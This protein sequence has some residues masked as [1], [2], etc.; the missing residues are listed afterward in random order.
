MKTKLFLSSLMSLLFASSIVAQDKTTVNAMSSEISDNLDLRA[1]ASIFGDSKD[2][3]DFENRL[4]DP[5]MQLSNLDLNNDNQVDYLRVIETVEGNSHL[6]VVQSVLGKDVFQDVATIEVERDSN[7]AIQVQV[8][9]DVYMYGT[10][11]IYE[12]VYVSTPVIYNYFWT[13]RYT[14]YYSS[15]YWGYYPSYYTFW[16]PYPVYRYRRNVGVWI[17]INNHYNYGYARRNQAVYNNY[18]GRRSNGY[19]RQYPNRS[20][21]S[22][23]EGFSN[24]RELEK[25]RPTRDVSNGTR[26]NIGTRNTTGT[27][28][29]T[30][31]I[32]PR[33][34][35]GSTPRSQTTTSSSPRNTSVSTPRSQTATSS[36]PR[37]TN[38]STPRSQTTNPAITPRSNQIATPR[39]ANLGRPRET[40]TPRNSNASPSGSQPRNSGTSNGQSRGNSGISG[41]R[42]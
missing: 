16:N 39:D 32:T 30:S 40:N 21:A 22:R 7:N 19:E 2:L 10:N 4:N 33:T 9:G 6:I 38:V 35:T 28:N 5:K 11:Y 18:Y 17:N 29:N 23:N 24:R 13:P 8:I 14:P 37:N 15:W 25:T 27:R 1:V 42:R 34:T 20:F 41:S 31:S 3:A 36:S 26:N 12:P